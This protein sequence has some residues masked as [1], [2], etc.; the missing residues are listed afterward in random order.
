MKQVELKDISVA[1]NRETL[2]ILRQV[3]AVTK[4]ACEALY[5]NSK[6]AGGQMAC[7]VDANNKGYCRVKLQKD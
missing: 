2:D 4:M 1:K 3:D 5:E 6:A 7:L